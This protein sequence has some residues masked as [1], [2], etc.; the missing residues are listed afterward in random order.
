MSEQPPPPDTAP[1]DDPVLE[2]R[3]VV[4]HFHPGR[5]LFPSRRQT[6]RAVDDISFTLHRGRTLGI[7]GESGCGKSTLARMTLGLETPTAGEI[8][9]RGRELSTVS[10]HWR[11]SVIQLVMQDPYSSLNPRMTIYDIVAEA[12]VAHPELVQGVRRRDLV[13]EML[14]L[15][16]LGAHHL[17]KFPH[18][19]SGGQR[20]RVGI[21]R[22]LAPKPSI[23]VC[24]EPVSALD[25]SVQAQVINLLE[26]LQA[27]LGLSYVF[28]SHDLSIVRHVSDRIAVIYLGRIV[29]EGPA[30]AVYNAPAHPYTQALLASI[31]T[32]RFDADGAEIAKPA[33][34]R[35]ELPDPLNPPS[36][37]PFRSR[38]FRARD[39]CAVE[40]PLPQAVGPDG[41]LTRCHFPTVADP[42]L[43]TAGGAPDGGRR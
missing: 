30:E 33:R 8:R 37:C 13:A 11:S 43:L 23:V 14:S 4:K 19:L 42:I 35:G 1:G 15:V 32:T 31:A 7:V 26:S 6:L 12:F 34:I 28:I 22:A 17:N 24:D 25:V 18:Q 10:R 20:Q 38:C 9:L 27:E 41:H 16:G 5:S 3:H 2:V 29:E 39:R 21:A 36:G 40:V